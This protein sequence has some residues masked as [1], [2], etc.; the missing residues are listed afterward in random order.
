MNPAQG[1]D[2]DRSEVEILCPYSNS[3]APG[4]LLNTAYDIEL[5]DAIKNGQV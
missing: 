4:G 3:R 2:I 1:F 5:S